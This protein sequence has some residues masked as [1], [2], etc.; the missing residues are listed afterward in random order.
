MLITGSTAIK[1]WIPSFRSPT[2]KDV[3]V[4]LGTITSKGI[5]AIQLPLD[6]IKQIPNKDGYL[7]MDALVT[8]KMS[9]MGWDIKWNKHKKDVIFLKKNG[10]NVIPELYNDLVTF[11]KTEHQNKPYL[12]LYKTKAEFFDDYVPHVY[13]HDYLHELIAHPNVPIYTKCLGINQQVAIDHEKFLSLPRNEQL[14]MFREEICVI[15]LERWIVNDKLSQ[16]V[17]LYYAY[18]FALHKTVTALTKNWACDF[19][20][21]NI[22]HYDIF[23]KNI[24]EHALTKLPFRHLL[25]LH[26]NLGSILPCADNNVVSFNMVTPFIHQVVSE[27]K[28]ILCINEK[29]YQLE[30][31]KCDD[32]LY[33]NNC[34][35]YEV[36]P[37][38]KTVI[39]YV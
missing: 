18:K 14:L 23:N 37:V 26:V 19:I 1:H 10:A 11:W 34:L 9:H 7:T 21:N 4:P 35:C 39:K 32:L 36:R 6:I 15:A 38:I 30:Y 28:L 12:S 27:N 33:D 2:D 31:D 3:I 29:Y 5:D 8:L 16:P 20:I 25:E 17:S 22:E 13:D 24:F